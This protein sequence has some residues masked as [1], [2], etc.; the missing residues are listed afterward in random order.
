LTRQREFV[1]SAWAEK[2]GLR[3]AVICTDHG[4]NVA[5][6]DHFHAA[7][8]SART[9]AHVSAIEMRPPTMSSIKQ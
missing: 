8:K 5:G 3:Y 6:A 7:L 9:S 4:N 2:V 1:P